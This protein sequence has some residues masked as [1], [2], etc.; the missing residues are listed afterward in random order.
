MASRGQA[1]SKLARPPLLRHNVGFVIRSGSQLGRIGASIRGL[2]SPANS[3]KTLT[4]RFARPQKNLPSFYI[5]ILDLNFPNLIKKSERPTRLCL[6]SFVYVV[7]FDYL[8]CLFMII[9]C[10]LASLLNPIY[11]YRLCICICIMYMYVRTPCMHARPNN[12]MM[13]L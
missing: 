8:G 12:V 9:K 11:I 13:V 2:V 4:T 3:F 6:M 7:V 5:F 1:T 10:I